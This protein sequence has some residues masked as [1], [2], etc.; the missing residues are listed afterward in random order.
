MKVG[1]VQLREVTMQRAA[2]KFPRRRIRGATMRALLAVAR[3]KDI[4]VYVLGVA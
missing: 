1:A 3:A 2:N 4:V